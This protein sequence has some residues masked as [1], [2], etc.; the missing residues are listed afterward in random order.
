MVLSCFDWSHEKYRDIVAEMGREWTGLLKQVSVISYF[1]VRSDW[2]IWPPVLFI[3]GSY[4]LLNAIHLHET[5][6]SSPHP[7][8]KAALL[9]WTSILCPYLFR[10]GSSCLI[11]RII[12]NA[13]WWIL[14]FRV[15]EKNQTKNK[16]L[17]FC[18]VHLKLKN[19]TSWGWM[20]FQTISAT[21]KRG[22][23]W[24]TNNSNN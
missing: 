6:F 4:L 1:S 24:R 22:K 3:V 12:H 5:F 17:K 19:F 7:H 23:K 21:Q 10:I 9:Y 18:K 14:K 2:L 15:R 11:Q 13:E 20:A 8:F 16:N